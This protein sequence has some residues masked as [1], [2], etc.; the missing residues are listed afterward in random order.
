MP[1]VQ[2]FMRAITRRKTFTEEEK[3]ET[4]LN[5]TLGLF[6]LTGIGVGSTL[7]AGVYVLSGE[8]ARESSG[9]A[10]ML[11]FAI[12]AFS[13]ILSGMCYAEFGARVPK[14]GSG[15]IYSYVTMGELCALTIGWN[16]VLSYVVGTSSV[17]KAWSANIDALINCKLRAWQVSFMPYMQSKYMED[18]PD[19][20]AAIIII[21]L[22]ALL[23]YGVQEVAFVNKVFTMVN[24]LV[25]IFVTLAGFI[26]ADWNNWT[27]TQEDV[28]RMAFG[29]DTNYKS[30]LQCLDVNHTNVAS[31]YESNGQNLTISPEYLDFVGKHDIV[32]GEQEGEKDENEWPGKGGFLP[33]GFGGVIAGTATCFYAFVGFD[34]IATTGEEAIN[35]Q[36]NI[37]ISIVLSLIVCCVA[38]LGVSTALTLMVPYFFLDKQAPLPA[39]FAYVGITWASY[40][41]G[42]GATCALTTSLLGAMFP[43]PRVIYS[44][45][46]DGILFRQLAAINSKT[47]TPLVATISSGLLA[48]FLAMIFDLKALVDFMSIG[49]LMAY[50]L[51]AASVMIL[52]YRNDAKYDEEDPLA[53][54]QETLK[55]SDFYS[56]RYS[57]P[58]VLST[59]VVTICSSALTVGCIGFSAVGVTEEQHQFNTMAW[60]IWGFFTLIIVGCSLCIFMQPE[61]SCPLDFKVPLIPFIPVV[62]V[63]VNI[64]LMVALPVSI[65]VKLLVWL[66]IGYAIYFFYGI[67]HSSENPEIKAQLREEAFKEKEEMKLLENGNDEGNSRSDGVMANGK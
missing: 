45:A 20:F 6:D 35:P 43:M 21:V 39:A 64:Y 62:N 57:M 30:G 38:Y 44:M 46:N 47:K 25:I 42:I 24:I 37:P 65:W 15:Y 34:A 36:R 60:V 28:N 33:Y 14:A 3:T 8:V 58:T 32:E 52:R 54:T 12:A 23:A 10:V 40:V 67:S 53:D 49:T 66:A 26:K 5:R 31:Y 48:A 1:S 55:L 2:N 18:Y 13:S 56:P 51:V 19:I 41:V 61:S 16:L 59:R 7:G 11:A 29:N 27:L 63:L 4:K 9:P 50:T 17:A 22:A